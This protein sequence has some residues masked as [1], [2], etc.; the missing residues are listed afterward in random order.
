MPKPQAQSLNS[1]EAVMQTINR[2][3]QMIDEREVVAGRRMLPRRQ[4]VLPIQIQFLG[5]NNQPC[6]GKISGI[7]LDISYSGMG[8]MFH[9]NVPSGRFAAVE[10]VALEGKH[11]PVLVDIKNLSMLGPFCRIG[12]TFRVNWEADEENGNES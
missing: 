1:P 11:V 6:T 3:N 2:L 9:G 10:F 12:G 8:F 4:I 5:E 7:S